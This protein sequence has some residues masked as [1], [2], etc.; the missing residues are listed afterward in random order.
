MSKSINLLLIIMCFVLITNVCSAQNKSILKL[1][2]LR[3]EYQINPRGVEKNQPFLS[4]EINS[5]KKRNVTQS[6]F[7]II[8]VE[9][10]KIPSKKP[11]FFWDS[12]V[13]YS[14]QS[15]NVKYSGK[16]LQSAKK[17]LLEGSGSRY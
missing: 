3:C 6:S 16:P 8:L 15:V 7:R 2:N 11:I 4:W 10:D 5:F 13:I 1:E 14:S 9:S 12:G 17:I